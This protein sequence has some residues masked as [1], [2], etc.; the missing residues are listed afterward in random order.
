M[1]LTTCSSQVQS[2]KWQV[3]LL[4]YKTQSGGR[5]AQIRPSPNQ[6]RS[7]S[8]C[9]WIFQEPTNRGKHAYVG[10]WVKYALRKSFCVSKIP[11]GLQKKLKIIVSVFLSTLQLTTLLVKIFRLH[12]H[13]YTLAPTKWYHH[14]NA[15]HDTLSTISRLS[16]LLG[17]F[18]GK[19]PF[20]RGY[21]AKE[22]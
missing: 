21:F 11:P 9:S 8:Q 16:S 20:F 12:F 22:T 14:L 3:W 15:V 2:K 10:L 4:L 1:R 5:I 17:L 13:C 18:R 6:N 19:A 7:E